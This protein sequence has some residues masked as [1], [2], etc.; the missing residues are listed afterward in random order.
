MCVSA[1]KIGTERVYSGLSSGPLDSH[2]SHA[3][4]PSLASNNFSEL[5]LLDEDNILVAKE[6][7]F[8]TIETELEGHVGIFSLEKTS[9][10]AKFRN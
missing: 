8:S 5:T 4:L 7:P 2:L 1:L 10:S 3:C 9:V 6:S